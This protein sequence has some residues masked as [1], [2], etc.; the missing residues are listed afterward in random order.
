MSRKIFDK[1]RK[2]NVLIT[3]HFPEKS[4]FSKFFWKASR[5]LKVIYENFGVRSPE[6]SSRLFF[7]LVWDSFVRMSDTFVRMKDSFVRMSNHSREWG[8]I[9][10]ADRRMVHSC[11]WDA[12]S[13]EWAY[14]RMAHSHEHIWREKQI[15][16]RH[17]PWE[18]L[19]LMNRHGWTKNRSS[20][21]RISK[22]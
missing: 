18:T 5:H 17:E 22:T 8:F 16:S 1:V 15:C 9:R 13:C 19:I 14:I 3:G 2:I 11:E 6:K 4:R 7:F 20:L 21:N 12:H 10:A